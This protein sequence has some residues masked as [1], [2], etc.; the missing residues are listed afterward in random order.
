MQVQ[1]FESSSG[2]FWQIHFSAASAAAYYMAKVS[3]GS[4]N[5]DV[6]SEEIVATSCG[7]SAAD[8]A[9]FAARVKRG[10]ISRVSKLLL[11][12][13]SPALILL[14]MLRLSRAALRDG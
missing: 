7:V 13:F 10:E 5:F 3:L 8:V 14:H 12:R 11:V 9:V 6:D 4:E 1:V 2:T